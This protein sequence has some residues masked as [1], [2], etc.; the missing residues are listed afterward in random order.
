MSNTKTLW[1]VIGALVL[2]LL[3]VTWAWTQSADKLQ[4]TA[5]VGERTI[6]EADWVA[7]LKEKYGQQVLS[8][9]I[10]REVV[11]QEAKRLG[12]QIE[13]AR[14]RTELEQ[15]RETYGSE[16]DSD[17][18]AAL[19]QQGGTTP[20]ALEEEI[21]YQLLLQE[22]AIRE[23]VIPE[24]E[25]LAYYHRFA[26]RYN[27]PVKV[28][29]WQ[30]VV[31]SHAEARQVMKELNSGANFSTLAKERSIDSLTAPGGGDAGWV[32]LADESLPPAA[33]EVIASLGVDKHSEP[34]EV[35]GKYVI[36]RIAD[37][38]EAQQIPFEQT[39]ESIRR[40]MALA[41]VESLDAFLD[42]LKESVG[43]QIGQLS[44]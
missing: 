16:T 25:L 1:A 10:N 17:F 13:P 15:I 4:A 20:E 5:V 30:I 42:R 29:L 36:Y 40:E 38:Q 28:R 43:V 23:I 21:T 27:H 24:E 18:R 26:D 22:L 7:K 31:A 41:Q 37:R 11:F 9:M 3:A 14:I 35:H 44:N 32:S 6:S 19:K 39:K 33:K 2:L 8:D 12:I 34:V